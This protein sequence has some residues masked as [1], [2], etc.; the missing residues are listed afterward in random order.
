MERVN[1]SER[2]RVFDRI[3]QLAPLPAGVTREAALALDTA[4]LTRWREELAW[5]W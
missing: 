1:R 4:T 3:V 5:L 2:G